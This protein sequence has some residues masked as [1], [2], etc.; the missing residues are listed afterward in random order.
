MS[1]TASASTLAVTNEVALA[2]DKLPNL[3]LADVPQEILERLDRAS[4]VETA[5]QAVAMVRSLDHQVAIATAVRD[6]RHDAAEL[7]STEEASA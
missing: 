1:D 7:I 6:A 5:T 2:A 3:H 4:L